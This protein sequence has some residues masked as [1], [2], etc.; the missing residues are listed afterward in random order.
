M[1]RVPMTPQ[2]YQKLQEDLKRFKAE[3][4]PRIIQAI[5]EAR[6]HGDLSENAEYDA[7]KEAQLHLDQRIKETEDKL[8]RAQ[9]IKPSEL[10]GDKV[11]F[12]A[13]VV[14]NDLS[15]EKK[16]TYQLVGEDE[17]DLSRGR[18]SIAS[19]LGRALVGKVKGEVFMFQSPAGERELEIEEI[20]FE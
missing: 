4:R 3:D 15:R 20:R 1:E 2:G 17:S 7:A 8:A 11:V 5:E 19:P 12:G 9:I 13:T 14:L 16:L 6:A 18:I 10:G